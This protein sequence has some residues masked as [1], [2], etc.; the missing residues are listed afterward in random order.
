VRRGCGKER[1]EYN[2]RNR[3][4][5]SEVTDAAS[6]ARVIT[7]YAYDAYGRRTVAWD[8]GREALR[9]VHVRGRPRGA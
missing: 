1:H 6:G 8:A 2:G 3:M 4:A 7:E 5:Y 9:R